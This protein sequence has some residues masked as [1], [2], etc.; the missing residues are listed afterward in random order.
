MYARVYVRVYVCMCVT[1]LQENLESI[2]DVN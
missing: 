2:V 1:F